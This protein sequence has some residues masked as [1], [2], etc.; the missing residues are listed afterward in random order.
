M[1]TRNETDGQGGFEI[2]L[3]NKAFESVAIRLR[4]NGAGPV[5]IVVCGGSALILMG[6]VHVLPRMSMSWLSR[7]LER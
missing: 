3:L 4:E 2:D 1:A 7:T 6:L 5:E